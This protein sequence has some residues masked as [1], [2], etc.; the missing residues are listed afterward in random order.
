MK[1]GNKMQEL[2]SRKSIRLKH[3]D[4]SLPGYYFI[5]ICTKNKECILSK[6]KHGSV[7]TDPYNYKY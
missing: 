1:E 2:H 5:T 6:I 7:K 3:Y 4:Y